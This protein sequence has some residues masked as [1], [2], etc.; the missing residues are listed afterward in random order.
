MGLNMNSANPS[1]LSTP[2]KKKVRPVVANNSK[3]A[4]L[5]AAEMTLRNHGF[6]PHRFPGKH[7]GNNGL[8]ANNASNRN[9]IEIETM[10]N[11]HGKPK[12]LPSIF[13]NPEEC[14]I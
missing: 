1:P 12:Q 5:K 4:P 13:E 14:S 2:V 6:K 9:R 8:K 11:K 3:F 10:S 7:G